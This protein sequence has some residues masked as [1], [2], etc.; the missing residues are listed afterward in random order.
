MYAYVSTKYTTKTK[1]SI[2]ALILLTSEELL[3]LINGVTCCVKERSVHYTRAYTACNNNNDDNR[4]YTIASLYSNFYFFLGSGIRHCTVIKAKGKVKLTNKKKW[5]YIY[6]YEIWWESGVLSPYVSSTVGCASNV[7]FK[8][9]H[10]LLS[11]VTVRSLAP[12]GILTLQLLLRVT[13]PTSI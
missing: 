8:P 9:D 2:W 3:Q 5:I 7:V 4:K 12:C 10:L 1:K 11:Q 13:R 6:V